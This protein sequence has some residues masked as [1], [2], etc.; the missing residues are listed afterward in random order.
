[1]YG[2]MFWVLSKKLIWQF[3]DGIKHDFYI[4]YILNSDSI[5]NNP[6]NR[7]KKRGKKKRIWGRVGNTKGTW[8]CLLITT[9]ITNI[10]LKKEKKNSY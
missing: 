6:I 2:R 4:P 1:M 7:P 5:S 3:L 8:K 9:I 10:T